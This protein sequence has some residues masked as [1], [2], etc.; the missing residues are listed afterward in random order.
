MLALAALLSLAQ[1]AVSEPARACGASELRLFVAEAQALAPVAAK[2]GEALLR[3][4][5]EADVAAQWL[6]FVYEMRGERSHSLATDPGRAARDTGAPPTRTTAI[7]GAR[8]GR[9]HELLA[10]IDRG[11]GND[12][13]SQLVL[14][15]A[16]VRKRRF[17]RGQEAYA[18]RS[19]LAP[20]DLEVEL[21]AAY[22][23]IWAGDLDDASARLAALGAK[24]LLPD[25]AAGRA[26]GEVLIAELRRQRPG[27]A[28]V[29][30][31]PVAPL[32]RGAATGSPHAASGAPRFGSAASGATASRLTAP[33]PTPTRAPQQAPVTAPKAAA[34]AASAGPAARASTAAPAA[35]A[36]TT[37]T[38]ATGARVSSAV[39]GAT[40]TPA[41][42]SSTPA[43]AHASASTSAAH[44]STI[45]PASPATTA[46]PAAT[47]ATAAT[48]S[49]AATAAT[50]ATASPAA[51][52]A[53]AS[54]SPSA[55]AARGPEA[56]ST[57]RPTAPPATAATD[58]ASAAEPEALPL[59]PEWLAS[60]PE[61]PHAALAAGVGF[62]RLGTALTRR[63]LRVQRSGAGVE[64]A[65]AA[66]SLA[67][68]QLEHYNAV[69]GEAMLGTRWRGASLDAGARAGWLA[70]GDG[71]WLGAA[72]TGVHAGGSPSQPLFTAR[73]AWRREALAP[74]LP[75][76][77]DDVAL[78]RDVA[79]V[80]LAVGRVAQLDLGV[81]KD[82]HRAYYERHT[83]L[84]AWPL[85]SD[86]A[87]GVTVDVRV[88]A[89][90]SRHR[91][92][93]PLYDADAESRAVGLGMSLGVGHEGGSR[94]DL[95][96]DVLDE[97]AKDR[98]TP[99][100]S[101]RYT[102]VEARLGGALVLK[103][104]WSMRLDAAWPYA[105]EAE[106]LEQ[107]ELA[108]RVTLG[109]ALTPGG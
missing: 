53:R 101:E 109:V 80:L 96:V 87:S 57:P 69:V 25:V 66:H 13:E 33:A 91:R 37:P 49:P 20:A 106:R 2:R 35:T 26:R 59:L 51:T 70:A 103:R 56:A 27:G 10:R 31:V 67:V 16:L 65:V 55:A 41:A 74:S 21:E 28:A 39:P 29:A 61:A 90:Y 52:A 58:A 54:T 22:A 92:P 98:G 77:E 8:A 48:A 45:A 7:V 15:R 23:A 11:L 47:A 76:I 63:T 100:R 64:A 72:D 34:Q 88:P 93:S 5:A 4:A 6:A 99:A 17:A 36:A 73:V 78:T 12:A 104:G 3:C 75:V 14:A 9:Y 105:S 107:H 108:R 68:E 42:R 60:A 83:A 82:L 94:A 38:A 19:A 44:A 95:I 86:E 62:A 84:F 50:A 79:D 40:A 102:L 85:A 32:S 24:A 97:T 89:A 30:V 46:S 81:G 71:A 18:A 1:A 43:P